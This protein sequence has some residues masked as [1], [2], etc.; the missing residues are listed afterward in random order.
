MRPLVKLDLYAVFF[1]LAVSTNTWSQPCN[2]AEKDVKKVYYEYHYLSFRDIKT[3][4]EY[5]RIEKAIGGFM[6]VK[7]RY[8]LLREKI[9]LYRSL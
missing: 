2:K 8:S 9:I 1:I 4:D 7:D 6:P 5:I 3:A